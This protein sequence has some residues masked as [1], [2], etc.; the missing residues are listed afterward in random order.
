MSLYDC[1]L[2]TITNFIQLDNQGF[3]RMEVISLTS[4]SYKKTMIVRITNE[5]NYD[6]SLPLHKHLRL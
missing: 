4:E 5:Q 2:W 6:T 3:M 1:D